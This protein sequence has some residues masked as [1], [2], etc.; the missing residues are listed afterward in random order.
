MKPDHE[1]K[2]DA[3]VVGSEAVGV[4]LEGVT[5]AAESG[6]YSKGVNG[7]VRRS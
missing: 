6:I 5:E 7:V 2:G 4:E 1:V 3:G